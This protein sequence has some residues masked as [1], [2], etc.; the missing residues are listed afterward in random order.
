MVK[1]VAF[2]P[3]F[4]MARVPPKVRVPDVV[5]GPPVRVS[6][7]VPPEPSTEVTVPDPPPAPIQFP[8]GKH[9][10]PVPFN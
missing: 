1:E 10:F 6:P 7:V 5:I 4:A 8:L 9:T 3:P 2:V